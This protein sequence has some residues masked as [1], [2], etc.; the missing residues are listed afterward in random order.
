MRYLRKKINPG[1]EIGKTPRKIQSHNQKKSET[2]FAM[3]QSSGWNWKRGLQKIGGKKDFGLHKMH[4][5]NGKEKITAGHGV[6][7]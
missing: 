5:D 7:R 2:K 3:G 4:Q 6:I 1:L